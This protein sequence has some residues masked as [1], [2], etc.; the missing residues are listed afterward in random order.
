V[1]EKGELPLGP[2]CEGGSAGC[3][4]C[5]SELESIHPVSGSRVLIDKI[6]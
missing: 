3:F 4:L 6:E 2:P 1:C 5:L